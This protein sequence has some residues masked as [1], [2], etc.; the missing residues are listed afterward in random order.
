MLFH[1]T[2]IRGLYKLRVAPNRLFEHPRIGERL[3][4]FNPREVRLILA[5]SFYRKHAN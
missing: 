2:R 1:P 5:A 3:D 4:A